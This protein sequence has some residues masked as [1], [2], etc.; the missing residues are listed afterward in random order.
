MPA[1]T[2]KRC[3]CRDPSTGRPLG[4]RCP[5]LRSRGGR[6]NARH[7]RWYYRLELPPSPDG[8]RQRLQR[9]GFDTQQAADQEL[10]HVHAL[11]ALP[12]PTDPHQLAEVVALLKRSGPLPSPDEVRRRLRAGIPLDRLPT[13]AQWL[14]EW[15]GGRRKIRPNTYRS[16]DSHIRLYLAPHLGHH[17]LDR[18]RVGHLDAM[19]NAIE[20][21]NQAIVQ[22][23]AS[24]DP[25][26]RASV[27]GQRVVGAASK[28]RI[29]ATLRAALNEAI[30]RQLIT[31]NVA[32]FVELSSG[33]RPK[34]LVWTPERVARWR[35]TGERPSPVMVWT[36]PQTGQ[37]LDQASGDPLYPLFQ[38][39]AFRGLRRGEACGLRWIDVDLDSGQLMVR[40]QLNQIGWKVELTDVKTE[41]SE[42]PVALDRHNVQVLRAHRAQQ[43]QQRL[44]AGPAWV[45]S[46]LVFTTPN[47][48]ALHPAEVT[49]RF[50]ELAAQ[51]GLP[52]IRLHDLR[53]GAATLAL[54]AGADMKVVQETLRHSSITITSDT[55]TSVLPEVAYAAAALVPRIV[56]P[57][58]GERRGTAS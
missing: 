9:G 38:L 44:A 48:Q 27:N 12:D 29:R 21:H 51:A 52:P 28:Q 11:L 56:P 41:S 20:D 35:A 10:E 31:V 14:A 43:L 55:Y 37:F 5:K 16:Y 46:G 17:R 8:T 34:A 25:T 33:R 49:D 6:W 13:V 23:R 40:K 1:V 53:H 22:A 30:R 3:G 4:T 24:H 57:T 58:P 50:L 7:G 36:P 54:A 39:A 42:A 26:L 18:L 47:G 32:S 2:L 45:D 15:L 19:F